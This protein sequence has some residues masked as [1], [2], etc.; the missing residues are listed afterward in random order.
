MLVAWEQAYASIPAPDVAVY[1][2]SRHFHTSSQAHLRLGRLTVHV[3]ILDLQ[4]ALGKS[5]TSEISPAINMMQRI[6]TDHPEDAGSIFIHCL[7]VIRDLRVQPLSIGESNSRMIEPPEIITCFLSEVFVWVLVICAEPTQVEFLRS[8]MEEFGGSD[9]FFA[10]VK[11]TLACDSD[12]RSYKDNISQPN[13]IM[14]AAAD[15]ISKMTPWNASL[16]LALLLCHRG[17][18][19]TT[20]KNPGHA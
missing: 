8:K 5:G 3:P 20:R 15:V 16:N 14:F 13:L 11:E 18:A 10:V 9:G 2:T 7:E 17:K 4:N 6:L 19:P 1:E 12:Q